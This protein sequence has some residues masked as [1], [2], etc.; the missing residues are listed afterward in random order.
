MNQSIAE[1]LH[2]LTEQ[3]SKLAP[4]RNG[5]GSKKMAATTIAAPKTYDTGRKKVTQTLLQHLRMVDILLRE[6]PN[7]RT[8]KTVSRRPR[9]LPLL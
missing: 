9:M 1:A 7:T 8:R 4:R 3:D 5:A 6:H 2:T